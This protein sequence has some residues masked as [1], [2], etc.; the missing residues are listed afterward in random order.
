MREALSQFLKDQADGI[1]R[2]PYLS[3]RTP[4]RSVEP[5]WESP[6][7][8]LPDGFTPYL[9]QAKSFERLSTVDCRAPQPTLVT[10]GTGSG[11][12]EC[13]LMP[14][15]DHCARMRAEGKGGIKALILYPMNALASDQAGRI[16]KT[17]AEEGRLAGVTAGLYVGEEGRHDAMGADHIIDKRDALRADP[18]DILLTNYKMLDFL[19]LRQ[20]DRDLWAVNTPDTLQYLVLDEFHTYDGAQGTDVAMLIR[21]LGAR[22]KMATAD[23]P[24]GTAT[25][26]ATSATLGSGEAALVELREFADKVFG[27]AF[28]P[29]SVIGETRQTVEE[30]CEDTEYLL[31]IPE[32]EDLAGDLELADVA[33]I[34]CS[35]PTEPFADPDPFRLGEKLLQH[36]LTRAILTA[37]GTRSRSWTDALQA[38]VAFAPNWGRSLSLGDGAGVEHALTQYLHLLSVARREQGG[39]SRPL[40]TIEVQ[41][42]IREVTR[43]L[44]TV[45]PDPSFRWRDSAVELDE[46]ELAAGRHELP[47]AFC[48]RCGMSGWMAIQQETTDTLN[49]NSQAIYQASMS[50][51]PLA[52]T[53]LRGH[54]DDSDIR[55]YSPSR[56]R[57]IDDFDDG[58]DLVPV[59]VTPSGADAK[60]NRCPGCNE[61]NSIRFLGLQ[62]ASLASVSINTLFASEHL[63]P[64]E[65]KLLAFTDS[66]QD[67]SH[68]A[69]FFG[70]RTHRINLRTLMSRIIAAEGSVALADLGDLMID[71]AVT[72]QDRFG[73][74]PPDLLRHPI[75]REVWERNPPVEARELLRARIGF[76]VDLE[77][78]LR[79]RV[80]RTL[81]LSRAAAAEVD[82]PG[83]DMTAALIG[84]HIERVS[85]DRPDPWH[86]EAYVR[87]LL[88]RM[89]LQGGLDHPLLEPFLTNGGRGWFLWGGRPDG[90][91]PFTSDQG[92]PS[93]F[94][95]APKGELASLTAA[96][97]KTP[98]WVNDWAGRNLGV[99]GAAAR[100]LNIFTLA[101]LAKETDTVQ[102]VGG[103]HATIYALDRR[104]V[105]AHDVAETEDGPEDSHVRCGICGH[106]LAAPAASLDRWLHTPCLRYRCVG[107]FE[108]CPPSV[109]RYYRNLYR[110]G[111]TRRVVT[112]EHTGL[113]GRAAREDLE[114]DFKEGTKPTAPNVLAATPTLE[115]G[116]DIG[117]LSAVMLTSVPRNPAS[118]IQ[119]VGRSGRASGNSLVT[120]FVKTDNHGLYYLA[121]P[122]N[123][124]SGDV[125]PPNCFLD[126]VETLQRQ[127][128]AYLFDRI[129]DNQ[130]DAPPLPNRV[131]VLIKA[132]LDEGAFLYA[133][134]QASKTDHTHIET[135][136]A[137]F[138]DRLADSTMQRLRS[139]A[140]AEIETGVKAA[141]E[142]WNEQASELGKR[143]KR[144]TDAIDRLDGETALDHDQ[145][146]DLA[147]LRGQRS[148]V[149]KLLHQLRREYSLSALERLGLLPNYSLIDDAVTLTATTWSKAGDGGYETDI[150]EYKRAGR[151][152]IKE[153][154]PGNWF[155]A[156][157][158][159]HVIDALE[160]GSA[161]EPLYEAW[162]LC[163]ECGYGTLDVENE[164][165]GVCPRCS[166]QG[167]ADT[168][169]R[170][171]MLRLRSALAGSSEEAARVYDEA[172]ERQSRSYSMVAPIDVD[173]AHIGQ[174]WEL[175]QR[176]FGAEFSGRTSL[177]TINL[178]LQDRTGQ[179]IPIAGQPHHVTGYTV[180]GHCGAVAE[181]RDDRDGQNPERLHQGWCKVK[182]G[183]VSA[184]WDNILLFHELVTEAIRIALPISMFEITE[185]LATFKGALL[186]GLRED[187]GGNPEHL[188]V[189][190]SD[191]PNRGGQ[192]RRRFLV[193]F[194]RVPG[195]TGYLA[196][197]ADPDRLKGILEEAR[198]VIARCACVS[199]GRPACHRC[200]L[201][202][203]NRNEYDVVRRDLALEILDDLLAEWTPRP[204]ETIGNVDLGKVE[205][206]ELERRFKVA[207]R[208]WTERNPVEEISLQTVPGQKG[209]AAFELRLG[210]LRY[211]ID[212]QPGLS[213]TPSTIPDYLIRRM[214][215]DGP[216]VAVYLDGLA[217]HAS[218]EHNNIAADAAK[219]RGVRGGEMLVWNLM[220]DDVEAFHKAATSDPQ[221]PPQ[222]RTLL[223]GKARRNAAAIQHGNDGHYDI[224]AL[225][226]NPMALLLDYLSRPESK[227]WQRLA[228]SA[229]GGLASDG[230]P[231]PVGADEVTAVISA[232]ISGREVRPTATDEPV[233]MVARYVTANDLPI[234]M[235]L[236][237]RAGKQNDERWT[238]ISSLQDSLAGDQ[239]A[240][241]RRWKDWLH[242]N[243]ILQFVG[244]PGSDAI[245]CAASEESTISAEDAWLA[246]VAAIESEHTGT[247]GLTDEMV[248]ELE[249]MVDDDARVLVRA[250]LERGAPAFVAGDEVDG[251]PLEAAWVSQRVAVLLAD[252]EWSG[253][254]WDARPVN[255]WTAEELAAVIQ[256]RS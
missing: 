31:P 161:Q 165:Q 67:A 240:H 15:L 207:L 118:Y 128:V 37:V 50:R 105:T 65:Q 33:A 22:L 13:F 116:I 100:D 190:I 63:E 210:G 99:E 81:E 182:S 24:L 250:V 217:Y 16:A 253:D 213:T 200:L 231:Q 218:P 243:N 87:G 129:A 215:A 98:T 175:E 42:W 3:V 254:G 133:A 96:P 156:A 23:R 92:R 28:G 54:P 172:D 228:A 27:T 151:L 121:E 239:E 138:G 235:L 171:M 203:V 157:G 152:A 211:R 153:F 166:S 241:V 192:G 97:G 80:G 146:M 117:D 219:R 120:T 52:R 176:A 110:S 159:R 232:G 108:P 10:T 43:L 32:V 134:V 49:V 154:A 191:S 20:E 230:A 222:L 12:T 131:G 58:D 216:S 209:F 103:G 45:D 51:S 247:T 101:L 70:G 72:A 60:A 41:L 242:W 17:I 114:K 48:R 214:D 69:A 46:E 84:E 224:A 6:L 136:L 150:V 140:A 29:D 208:E 177:R 11:K 147:S 59:L 113:L 201:G 145:E 19:L 88:E 169:S 93:F 2:G 234:T 255:Q 142:E 66:V 111:T 220:W 148:A 248:E 189:A 85:G 123:M 206:S 135:F 122:Q 79:S 225:D 197:M 196:R 34:F 170:H 125:R 61:R 91:P 21:R 229:V 40:F 8:W 77:F 26:I 251:V 202:V 73:L 168:G 107:R 226:Q 163:P 102:A 75:I 112:G 95:T 82:L 238:V 179:Q 205:E 137:L 78:G 124:I 164:T 149:V 162:R 198:D 89:R 245:L 71:E 193:L 256:E 7:E 233:A 25:P 244:G 186:L 94:T 174:A 109:G 68:R 221:R 119:R 130:I 86:V 183:N 252:D 173:P 155:Y 158:H 160:V 178:G 187:F 44:R 237:V 36:P 57:L 139:F 249:L 181:T 4:F 236:D 64:N 18:P 62:V 55:W 104:F 199:E 30:A 204:V 115:M 83:L 227:H 180:C 184:K 143:R 188:E 90:L 9:H 74:V 167:M 246:D 56:R 141:I 144:L 47:A 35:T 76:E 212:E 53:L 5:G 223:K 132:G 38:I 14:V 1:F 195:G 106:L 126:A 39:T 185:R 127:Y 194:D